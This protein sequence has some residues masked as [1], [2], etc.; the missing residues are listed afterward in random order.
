MKVLVSNIQLLLKLQC[1]MFFL[2]FFGRSVRH[3]TIQIN[4]PNRCKSFA[5]LLL[6]VYV[7]LNMFRAPPRPASR[8][9]TCINSLWFYRWNVAVAAL[10][11]VVWPGHGQQRCYH[12]VSTVKPEAVNAVVELLV[13]GMEAPETCLAAQNVK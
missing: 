9:Y 10:L 5:R 11:A 1:F 4:Q 13:M 7:S 12:Y 2:V 8:V 6:D 3:H